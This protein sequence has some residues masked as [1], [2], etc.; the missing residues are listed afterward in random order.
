MVRKEEADSHYHHVAEA[1]PLSALLFCP[2]L[3]EERF[4]P[5]AHVQI[6]GIVIGLLPTVAKVKL[7]CALCC[8][9]LR[10]TVVLCSAV[11]SHVSLLQLEVGAVM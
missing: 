5:E 11:Q 10:V 4:W 6:R 8:C 2:P 9:F 3:C 7:L 1:N